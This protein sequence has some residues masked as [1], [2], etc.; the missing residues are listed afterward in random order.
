MESGRSAQSQWL[1]ETTG[2]LPPGWKPLGTVSTGARPQLDNRYARS[3]LFDL[4]FEASDYLV[5]FE[6]QLSFTSESEGLVQAG[7]KGLQEQ[8]QALW[9]TEVVAPAKAVAYK[10]C[11]TPSGRSM[12]KFGQHCGVRPMH[13]YLRT[14]RS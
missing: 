5:G 7:Y 8:A 13:E 1:Q 3:R 11:V 14:A 10:V 4:I 2:Q 12:W 6:V 9:V